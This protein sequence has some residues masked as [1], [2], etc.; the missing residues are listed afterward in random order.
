MDSYKPIS[1]DFHDILEDAAVRRLRIEV[2]FN[3]EGGEQVTI[4]RIKDITVEGQEEFLIM[5]DGLKLRLD[6]LTRVDQQQAE[7]YKG[8]LQPGNDIVQGNFERPLM[9]QTPQKAS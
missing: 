3:S 4:G 5:E 7:D 1:C 6:Q 8:E 9:K 2:A